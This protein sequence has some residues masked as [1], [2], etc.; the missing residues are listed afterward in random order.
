MFTPMNP[1]NEQRRAEATLR[2]FTEYNEAVELFARPEND[3]VETVELT[4]NIDRNQSP[5]L[6]RVFNAIKLNSSESM[7]QPAYSPRPVTASSG[8]SE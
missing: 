7:Q 3:Q 6:M 2:S 1:E 4:A 8:C 5:I